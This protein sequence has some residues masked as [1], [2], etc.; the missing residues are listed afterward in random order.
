MD[1][2]FTH[3]HHFRHPMMERGREDV[4]CTQHVHGKRLLRTPIGVPLDGHS[5]M[6]DSIDGLDGEIDIVRAL[7][8]TMHERAQ[9]R[10][11][12][13]ITGDIRQ[14]KAINLVPGLRDS[15]H[16]GRGRPAARACHKHSHNRDLIQ[17]T[18]LIALLR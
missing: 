15:F 1:G 3:Q 6:N 5:E 12:T 10:L 14:I 16:D 18:E 17:C 11:R 2:R 13:R 9:P 4:V 8:S 7:N